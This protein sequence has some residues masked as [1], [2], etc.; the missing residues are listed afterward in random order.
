MPIYNALYY[1]IRTL[2]TPE[3]IRMVSSV[4]R[5]D[6]CWF[7]KNKNHCDEVVFIGKD[8]WDTLGGA[9]C[10]ETILEIASAV[11]AET[12]AILNNGH[13]YKRHFQKNKWNSCF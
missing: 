3:N 9:G 1:N 12:R 13:L 8:Y 4:V 10:Y 6:D 7:I 2:S 11:G 5:A